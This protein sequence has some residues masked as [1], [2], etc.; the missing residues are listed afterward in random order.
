MRVTAK[1]SLLLVA[2]TLGLAVP[3]A[4]ASP[5]IIFKRTALTVGGLTPGGKAVLFSVAWDSE[6]GVP[7][8]VRRE[9]LLPDND[10]DGQVHK[11]LGR[12]IPDRSVWFAVDLASGRYTVGWPF[13]HPLDEAPF[14][15]RVAD[16]GDRLEFQ[17]TFVQLV[18]VRPGVGAWGG[19]VRDGRSSDPDATANGTVQVLLSR[20][21]P[22]GE[23]LPA[24]QT[25]AT[26][27][28]LLIVDPDR[29]EYMAHQLRR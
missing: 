2:L 29:G 19:R 3:A 6:G 4:A 23:S 13:R 18:L 15:Q 16:R 11:D 14:V 8:L 12:G 25:M 9:S 10:G 20:M 5:E 24:P 22:L 27:D 17:R 7:Q 28:I 26:G 21:W 1:P